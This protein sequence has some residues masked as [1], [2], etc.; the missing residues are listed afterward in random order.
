[1]PKLVASRRSSST[2][3]TQHFS[4]LASDDV[5]YLSSADWVAGLSLAFPYDSSM[6]LSASQRTPL[7]P[8]SQSLQNHMFSDLPVSTFEHGLYLNV[9]SCTRL[10]MPGDRGTY[11]DI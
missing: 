5:L 9:V 8:H 6:P 7:T 11:S 4:P 3:A 10:K 1:M 2:S